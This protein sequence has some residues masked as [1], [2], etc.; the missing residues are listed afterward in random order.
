M[1]LAP[2]NVEEVLRLYKSDTPVLAFAFKRRAVEGWA[3]EHSHLRGQL[4]ALTQGLLIV[5]AGSRG[6]VVFLRLLSLSVRPQD[7]PT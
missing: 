6:L 7:Q 3:P 4:I 1:F 5:E 2:K